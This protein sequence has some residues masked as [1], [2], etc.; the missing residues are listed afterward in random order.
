MQ[1]Q[2]NSCAITLYSISNNEPS[3]PPRNNLP[4]SE[5]LI[6]II[7]IPSVGTTKIGSGRRC[8]S[9]KAPRGPG[10][11]FNAIVCQI[12]HLYISNQILMG[13]KSIL[14]N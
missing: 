12:C 4:L 13:T 6:V 5:L 8:I 1:S 14:V 7:P 11:Y 3:L 9:S 10:K 2:F